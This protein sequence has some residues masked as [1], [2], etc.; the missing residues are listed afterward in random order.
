[1]TMKT[2]CSQPGIFSAGDQARA[3]LTASYYL[4]TPRALGREKINAGNAAFAQITKGMLLSH[5]GKDIKLA[6]CW[7]DERRFRRAGYFARTHFHNKQVIV[8]DHRRK[9]LLKWAPLK[10]WVWFY[11]SL[12]SLG[13]HLPQGQ[14]VVYLIENLKELR[15][16][17]LKAPPLP[18]PPPRPVPCYWDPWAAI[19]SVPEEPA[20]PVKPLRIKK[21]RMGRRRV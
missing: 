17:Q 16:R 9:K 14:G 1:V 7:N 19:G 21:R 18:Q 12:S 4:L 3:C 5:S 20:A 6:A 13:E 11:G 15:K 2:N 10:K 8:L